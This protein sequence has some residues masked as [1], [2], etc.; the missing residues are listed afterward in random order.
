MSGS[1]TKPN[2]LIGQTVFRYGTTS[3]LDSGE[4]SSKS[5][6]YAWSC[7][8]RTCKLFNTVEVS[9]GSAS[10]DSGSGYYRLYTQDGAKRDAY[11]IVSAG[12]PGGSKTHYYA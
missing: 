12:P 10:G 5:N 1:K 11:G 6:V 8:P 9:H 7:F 4:I 2:Q 3:G